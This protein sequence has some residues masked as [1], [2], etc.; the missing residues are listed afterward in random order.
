MQ[1]CSQPTCVVSYTGTWVAVLDPCSVTVCGSTGTQKRWFKC[2]TGTHTDCDP[3]SQSQQSGA[4][5]RIAPSAACV[6]VDFAHAPHAERAEAVPPHTRR[7]ISRCPCCCSAL[8]LS[9]CPARPQSVVV[10]CVGACSTEC[11]TP[12]VPFADWESSVCPKQG[13]TWSDQLVKDG[14]CTV[15]CHQPVG[16]QVILICSGGKV[17]VDPKTPPCAAAAFWDVGYGACSVTCGSGYVPVHFR[18]STGNDEDCRLIG[19]HHSCGWLAAVPSAGPVRSPR[20]LRRAVDLLTACRFSCLILVRASLPPHR[21]TRRRHQHV[22]AAGLRRPALPG[23][24][25]GDLRTLQRDRVRRDRQAE[26]VVPMQH[27]Q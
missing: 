26:E 23:R 16:H 27:G 11:I 9:L 25:A 5:V 21:E 20:P 7:L 17:V 15:R 3:N 6:L 22:R 4:P 8:L 14:R 19:Q 24:V 13:G 2:S 1:A 18:C 10:D 12:A